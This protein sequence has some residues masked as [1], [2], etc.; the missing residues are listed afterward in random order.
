MN[1]A[2]C[3][4]LRQ[5]SCSYHRKNIITMSSNKNIICKLPAELLDRV[6]GYLDYNTAKN[7]A[8]TVAGTRTHYDICD[9]P[10]HQPLMN[11]CSER[12][13]IY[14]YLQHNFGE[15]GKLLE[16]MSKATAYLSG[17]RAVEFFAPG[18]AEPNSDWDIYVPHRMSTILPFMYKLETMGVSWKTQREMFG[19]NIDSKPQG[20]VISS[21]DMYRIQ[22]R[23]AR[24][25]A[26]SRGLGIE[27]GGLESSDNEWF[28]VSVD[29]GTVKVVPHNGA[30]PDY[31]DNLCSVMATGHVSHGG[32]VTA[33]QLLAENRA[34]D[35]YTPSI[36]GHH[37]SCT[38][39]VI[40]PY[41]AFHIYG[42]MACNYESYAWSSVLTHRHIDS[43]WNMC[44]LPKPSDGCVPLWKKYEKRGYTYIDAPYEEVF[45]DV[46]RLGEEGAVS[47]T[48]SRHTSAPSSVVKYYTSMLMNMMWVQRST[49]VVDMS[50][51]AVRLDWLQPG[52]QVLK[53]LSE[54]RCLEHDERMKLYLN[55]TV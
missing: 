53:W 8:H 38:Q 35:F 50:P 47:L 1:H 16:A 34:K 9:N 5:Q 15:S 12:L 29:N 42:D 28:H 11:S 32:S 51:A 43:S 24:E 39:A 37:S 45:M 44:G 30:R 25:E 23:G 49:K 27:I 31:D 7:L 33:V 22:I 2:I 41:M 26:T 13:S 10:A 52:E 3:L 48:Y 6:T 20:F 19:I 55:I 46:R 14:K 40:S 4:K 36:F 18:S 21:Q 17:S 54:P